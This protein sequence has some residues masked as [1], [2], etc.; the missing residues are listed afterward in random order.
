MAGAYVTI[1]DRQ[2]NAALQRLLQLSGNL[3]PVFR[4]IG[5]YLLISTRARF[6]AQV[7]PEGHPWKRLSPKYLGEKPYNQDKI[8]VLDGKLMGNLHYQ[9]SPGELD[10]GSSETYAAIHQFGGDIQ[11]KARQHTLY[12]HQYA[13]GRVG[14]RFVK[15]KHA[16]F[17]QDV[18]MGERSVHMPARP[19]IG[20]STKDEAEILARIYEHLQNAV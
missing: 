7:D 1:D 4:D 15:K 6:E 8:L 10:F 5:E 17:A 18:A 9:V 16:N 2:I 13:D 14:T 19:F 11:H 12:F 3:V 20:V